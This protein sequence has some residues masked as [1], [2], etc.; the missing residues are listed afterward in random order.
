MLERWPQTALEGYTYMDCYVEMDCWVEDPGP[1]KND[2]LLDAL[3]KKEV[4]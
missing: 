4:E 1:S 2:A 3:E